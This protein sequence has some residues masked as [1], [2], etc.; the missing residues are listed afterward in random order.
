MLCELSGL[1]LPIYLYI[2]SSSTLLEP[3]QLH[4]GASPRRCFRSLCLLQGL[5]SIALRID[6]LNSSWSYSASR[7]RWRH[8][9]LG[10]IVLSDIVMDYKLLIHNLVWV[11]ADQG[12]FAILFRFPCV[13]DRNINPLSPQLGDWVKL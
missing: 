2:L 3:A 13:S 4:L 10:S 5:F 6:S 11:G 1:A 8:F 12:L 9:M 7:W